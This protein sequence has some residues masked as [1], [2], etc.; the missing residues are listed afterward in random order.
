MS[1]DFKLVDVSRWV[2]SLGAYNIMALLVA[3]AFLLFLQSSMSVRKD[4]QEPPTIDPRLPMFGHMINMLRQGADYFS[5]LERRYHQS[6]YVLILGKARMYVVTSPEWAQAI[7]KSHKSLHFNTLIAQAMKNL[8]CMDK[9]SM[10]IINHNVNGDDGTRSGI[11][12]EIHDMLGSVLLPGPHL[13]ELNKS[14]LEKFLPDINAL[15]KDGPQEI[16]L[17]QYLR[18]HFSIASTTAIWGPKN[19]FAIDP[20]LESAF[21]DFEAN[22]LQLMMMPLPHLF[23][24]KAWKARQRVFDA[25]EL[26]MNNESYSEPGTSTM[27]RKRAEINMGKFGLTPKMHAYGDVSFVFG[28][29][30]NT[31][32]AAF[33]LISY[34]FEDPTLLANIRSEIDKCT[35]SFPSLSE[36]NTLTI[37]ATALR[38]SCPLLTASLRE[39]LRLTGS[40][41]INRHVAEDVTVTNSTTGEAFVLKKDSMVQ[42]ASNVIHQREGVWGADAQ[43]FNPRRFM[44]TSS[45]ATSSSTTKIPDPAAPFRSVDGKVH[46]AAFRSFGGGNNICPGRFFAQ[47]EILALTA[48][49][50]AG[51]EIEGVGTPGKYTRPGFEAWKL[52]LGVLKP[53]KDVGVRV[54]RRKGREGVVWGLEM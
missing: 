40:I 54:M 37:N 14:I 11:M 48:V 25:F 16:Q 50:V 3:A 52:S 12:M 38:T 33:W 22:M 49:F 13:D 18:H 24:R 45:S 30:V 21:W 39:V 7:H 1:Q 28:A 31:I 32:P 53:G 51:F 5:E 19:P 36:P 35:T 2:T 9:Q 41:N 47:T 34:I 4:I 44:P 42:I 43:K 10:E 27:I 17:W 15:A 20:D 6:M 26:Y 46:S 29:V 23:A 8:F